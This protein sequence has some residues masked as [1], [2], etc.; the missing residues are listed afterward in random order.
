MTLKFKL[1]DKKRRWIAV[2]SKQ[3][4]LYEASV[5][6]KL[7]KGEAYCFVMVIAGKDPNPKDGEKS[8]EGQELKLSQLP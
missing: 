4:Q 6:E 7:Y 5:M 2:V 8:N 3:T 1:E